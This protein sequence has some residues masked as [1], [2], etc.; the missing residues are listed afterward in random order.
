MDPWL[1][2]LT[3]EDQTEI[4][5][6]Y[7]DYLTTGHTH[8]GYRVQYSTLLGYMDCM[9]AWIQTHRWQDIRLEAA[10][11]VAQH[12]WT[13]HPILNTTYGGM[14]HW[15]GIPNHQ[16]SLS[17]SMVEYLRANLIGNNTHLFFTN[18]I[19]Y[20]L[21]MGFQT[22]WKGA[23]WVHSTCPEKDGFY[24]YDKRSSKFEN[25]IYACCKEDF[26]FKFSNGQSVSNPLTTPEHK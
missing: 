15:Q 5:V 22:G 17:K 4:A 3:P 7:L 6:I 9:A 14:K 18:A 25:K 2:D 13:P 24:L 19:I 23:K 20:F 8:F 26:T 12:L 11:T 10:T 16:N 21:I 1:V